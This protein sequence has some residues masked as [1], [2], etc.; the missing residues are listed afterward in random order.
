LE[1]LAA[2]MVNEYAG[3]ISMMFGFPNSS[4]WYMQSYSLFLPFAALPEKDFKDI[5]RKEQWARWAGDPEFGNSK[6]Y[7][8][9]IQQNHAMRA[10][11]V[12]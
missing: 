11:M 10:K 8:A 9:N 7:W 1:P 12:K 4:R 6:M 3:D 5:L 2:S